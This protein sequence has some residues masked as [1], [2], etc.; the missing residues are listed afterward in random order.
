VERLFETPLD[1]PL[2][3]PLDRSRP[4]RESLRDPLI[5][6]VRSFGIGLQQDLGTP[7]LLSRPLQFLDNVSK[8]ISLLLRQSHDISLLHGL[9]PGSM[10]HDR[11]ARICQPD[12]LAVTEH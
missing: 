9:P 11:P 7:N 10:Q 6:P 1:Q 8:L 5:G 2:P 12:F 3:E 4:T